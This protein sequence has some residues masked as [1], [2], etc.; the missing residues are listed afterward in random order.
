LTSEPPPP[1]SAII[2]PLQTDSVNGLCPSTGFLSE[3][4]MPR[5]MYRNEF[6]ETPTQRF[7]PADQQPLMYSNQRMI[8]PPSWNDHQQLMTN[9]NPIRNPS[10]LSTNESYP[11]PLESLERLLLLPESQVIEF[12]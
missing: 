9:Q 7:Y 12:Q 5:M 4:S 1:S 6:Y 10:L 3:P 11:H 8:R 2:H